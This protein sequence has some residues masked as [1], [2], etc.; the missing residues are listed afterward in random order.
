MKPVESRIRD[1]HKQ[2][3]TSSKPLESKAVITPFG[4]LPEVRRI[5][6]PH[7]SIQLLTQCV[8][9]LEASN[10]GGVAVSGLEMAQNS[11]RMTWTTEEVD[12][13]LNKIMTDCYNVRS[14]TSSFVELVLIIS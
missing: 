8:L 14:L 9:F 11:Q 10:C 13:K 12:S 5:P 6:L 7:Q 2:Q 3:S 4:M 1:A